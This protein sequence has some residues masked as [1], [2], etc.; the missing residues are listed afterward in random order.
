MQSEHYKGDRTFHVK[1]GGLAPKVITNQGLQYRC[2]C[3]RAGRSKAMLQAALRLITAT[4]CTKGTMPP[5]RMGVR[6]DWS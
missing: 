4:F 5:T 2:S 6:S 1:S 3:E